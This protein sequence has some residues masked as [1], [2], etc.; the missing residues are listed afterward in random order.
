M[1]KIKIAFG[2]PVYGPQEWQWWRPL[3]QSAAALAAHGIELVDIFVEDSMATDRNRNG[4]V[5]RCM[6]SAAEWLVWIDADNINPLQAVKQLLDT[7]SDGKKLV[8]GIYYAK[9]EEAHYAPIA[10]LREE[11]GTFGQQVND[12]RPLNGWNRGEILAI[13][14]AGMNCCLSHRSVY[15]DIDKAYQ[16]LRLASGGY[17]AVHRDDVQGDVFDNGHAPT[18]G[19]VI[20]GVWHQRMYPPEAP[21]D[22][23][24]FELRFARTEDYGFFEKAKR[25]G[26][27]LWLDT[28]VECGHMRPDLAQGLDYRR[29]TY[30]AVAAETARKN[31]R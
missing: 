8:S 26:H 28:A 20:E 2:I 4:I 11:L 15:E 17:I 18:D 13:D 31:G 12:Y 30:E 21:I 16:V 14:A 29:A 9:T 10:Y 22:V 6:A 5:R 19:Q 1:A 3:V 27:Q 23:P 7:A 24:F 25:V